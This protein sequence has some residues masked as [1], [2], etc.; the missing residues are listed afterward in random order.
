MN[1]FREKASLVLD[2]LL[3]KADNSV[4]AGTPSGLKYSYFQVYKK[5]SNY[6]PPIIFLQ[7]TKID[8]Y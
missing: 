2:S 6:L 7:I 5:H 1:G 3:T 4:I 8:R